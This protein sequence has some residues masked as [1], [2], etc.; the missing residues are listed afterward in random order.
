[1]SWHCPPPIPHA[2][3]PARATH[4]TRHRFD[5]PDMTTGTVLAYRVF[6]ACAGVVAAIA[7][8]FFAIGIGDG[9]VSSFNLGLWLVLLVGLGTVLWIGHT[10]RRR[11]KTG[12]AIAVLGIVAVPG[13]LGG[14]FMLL[15]VI[16]QPRWN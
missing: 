1:M 13:L 11:D 5:Q 2:A 9:S 16:T 8:T 6:L 15:V 14:L 10:L 3:T 4:E 12:L 7:V